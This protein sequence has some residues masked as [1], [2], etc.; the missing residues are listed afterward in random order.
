MRMSHSTRGFTLVELLVVIAIIGILVALLLPAVQAAREAA[1]RMQ[2]S[3]N[4]KQIGLAMHNYHDTFKVFPPGVMP[5]DTGRQRQPSWIVRTF[6]F[7]EQSTTFDQAVFADTDWTGQDRADRNWKIK[8]TVEVGAFYCPSSDMDKKRTETP[9]GDTQALGAPSSI[10]VQ[11]SCY[12]GIAGTYYNPNDMVSAPSPN[13]SNYGRATFNGVM[14]SVGGNGQRSPVNFA[15]IRDGTSNTICVAEQSAYYKDSN[16]NKTDCRAGLWA[17]GMWACGPGG[18]ADWWL[19]VTV[20]RYPINWNGPASDYC[21]G[22]RKHT[23]TRSNHPGGA[24]A[25]LSDGSVRFV[26]ETI[27]FGTYMRLCDRQDGLPVGEY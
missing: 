7:L 24:Q 16:N 15:G 14:A 26:S 13:Y 1:R 27:D 6:P 12:A 22:Y 18:D 8:N 10:Q 9:R 2:C 25:V 11:I 23:I 17:G 19:N 3:N 20:V 4:Q 5:Q 21:P